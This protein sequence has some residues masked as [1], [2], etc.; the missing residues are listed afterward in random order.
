MLKHVEARMRAKCDFLGATCDFDCCLLILILMIG[1][2]VRIEIGN[3]PFCTVLFRLIRK[4]NRKPMVLRSFVFRYKQSHNRKRAFYHFCVFVEAK[5]SSLENNAFAQHRCCYKQNRHG[6]QVFYHFCLFVE[7][8]G[9]S[10]A[11]ISF[12]Q[13]WSCYKQKS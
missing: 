3:K 13:Q 11:N 9:S 5:V 8:K 7:A 1:I 6:K 10:L 4:R 2:Q 12:A